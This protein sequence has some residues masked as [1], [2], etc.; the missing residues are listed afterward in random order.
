M[1]ISRSLYYYHL[2][3]PQNSYEKSNEL[4]EVEIKRVYED[5]K[6]RYGAPKITRILKSKGFKISEK[7]VS[8]IM[9]KA[10]LRS[11][12]VKKFNHCTKVISKIILGSIPIFLNRILMLKNQGK[13]G[14][15]I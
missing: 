13:N 3:N 9:R 15:V 12:T 11:I 7:R 4:M 14:L 6:G 2:N 10:G 5:S 8:K 1:D